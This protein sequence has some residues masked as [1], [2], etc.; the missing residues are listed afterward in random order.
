METENEK[1]IRQLVDESI[2]RGWKMRKQ[3]S[4]GG[5]FSYSTYDNRLVYSRME[6]FNLVREGFELNENSGLLA[7][8]I[9]LGYK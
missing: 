3:I 1:T 7:L 9:L 6:L 8:N 4:S 2:A 5:L